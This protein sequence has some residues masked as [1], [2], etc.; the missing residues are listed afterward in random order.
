MK[1]EFFVPVIAHNMRGYD[2]HL[3]IKHMEKSFACENIH[4]I[5]SNTEKFTAFQIGQLRF[6]DSL[7]F[8]NASLDA[9]V[10]NLKRDLEKER[11][12][13]FLHT[14]RHY[15]DEGSFSRVTSKGVYPYEYMDGVDKFQEKTLPSIENFFS[16]LYD[17]SITEEE[18][19]RAKDVWNH[20]GIQDM[21][22]YHDLYLK[23]DTLLLADVFE[24]FR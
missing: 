8:L 4:V 15:P 10:S 12:N 11:V 6:L 19:G 7:Q 20:F 17:E 16:K 13:R 3:I 9:L 14:R 22:Q 23:T 5:A 21:H 24:N 1:D 18:Y 2:S